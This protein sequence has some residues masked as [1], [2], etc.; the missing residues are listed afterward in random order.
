MAL[1]TC[2]HCGSA[3]LDRDREAPAGEGIPVVCLSC[4]HRFRRQPRVVCRRCGSGDVEDVPIDGWGFDDLEEAREHPDTASWS[5][6][7]RVLHRCRACRLEWQTVEGS[8]PYQLPESA[9]R[10]R[11]S[12][13]GVELSKPQPLSDETAIAALED[14]PGVHVV[15]RPDG[16]PLY[17]G[18][19]RHTRTR[20]RQHL[21]GDREAS[22]L[23]EKVGRMLDRELG[24]AA[25]RDEIR[26]WLEQ[27]SF[28]VIY[29]DDLA[30]TKAALMSELTP[31]LNEVVPDETAAAPSLPAQSIP[32]AVPHQGSTDRSALVEFNKAMHEVYRLAKVEAGYNATVFLRMLQDRGPLETARFLI[33]TPKPSDGFTA[34]WERRRLDLTV[35][36]HVLQDRFHELFTDDEREICRDRLAQYGYTAP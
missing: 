32:D 18:M 4:G 14:N 13:S 21:T 11:T 31:E 2:E 12:T 5:Y 9:P 20:I 28:A 15:F 22:I 34:L 30:A 26:A 29:T 6:V 16:R 8:H 17:V 27:C 10:P 23:H 19:S 35:E 3:D 1:V 7:D 24:R 36:A 33:H 25:T